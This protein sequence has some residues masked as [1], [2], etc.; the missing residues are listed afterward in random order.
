MPNICSPIAG[1]QAVLRGRSIFLLIFE[2]LSLHTT[3]PPAKDLRRSPQ[4][5]VMPSRGVQL[6]VLLQCSYMIPTSIERST[7]L[8]RG[9]VVLHVVLDNDTIGRV[10]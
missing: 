8:V 10:K 2:E 1:P 3:T 4:M 5:A 6:G 9:L 7:P